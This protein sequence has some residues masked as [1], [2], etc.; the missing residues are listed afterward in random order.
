MFNKYTIIRPI[1]RKETRTTMYYYNSYVEVDC[2]KFR[3][4][5]QSIRADLGPETAVIPVLKCDAYGLGAVT[6][7]REIALGPGAGLMAVAQ[8]GEA[9]TLRE[10]GIACDLLVLAGVPEAHIAPAVT[11]SIQLAC[12]SV[13]QLRQIAGQARLQNRRAGIQLK[14]ETGLNRLGVRPGDELALWIAAFKQQ[15]DVDLCG[16]Y[17]HFIDAEIPGSPLAHQQ[18]ALYQQA[19]HQLDTAG[20]PVPL[21]HICNSGASEW[22]RDAFLDAARIGRRLYMDAPANPPPAGTP[23][24]VSE[25]ASWR[26]QVVSLRT[27]A[28][29]ETTGYDEAFRATRPT[30]VAVVSAGYGDGLDERLGPARAPVLVDDG[31]EAHYLAVCMDQSVLDVTDIPCRV[32]DEVTFYGY[33]SAGAFLSAQRVAATIGHEGVYLTTRLGNRVQRVYRGQV[34]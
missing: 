23:G 22:Y 14:I 6:L 26:A 9:I 18:L 16:V 10:S 24:A 33:T 12:Y 13:P 28:I 1:T 2:E 32:G 7:A 30:T 29:G 31:H 19:L 5:I 3:N 20:I 15:R 4:N 11:H 34:G 27:L 21:R 17:A 25:I 8:V